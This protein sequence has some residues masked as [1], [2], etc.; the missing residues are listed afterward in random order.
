[1]QPV[2]SGNKSSWNSTVWCQRVRS[3][4]PEFPRPPALIQDPLTFRGTW[5][6][7]GTMAASLSCRTRS[8]SQSITLSARRGT[9]AAPRSTFSRMHWVTVKGNVAE[10]SGKQRLKGEGE[11]KETGLTWA[12]CWLLQGHLVTV[13]L[14]LT[15]KK[16]QPECHSLTT[17]WWL[18]SS[19]NFLSTFCSSPS[20]RA[21][22]PQCCPGAK[23]NP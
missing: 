12:Q 5:W 21:T 20:T 17:S 13:Q 9:R 18:R 14:T 16:A 10:Q 11:L 4:R 15:L 23:L 1:M 8:T 7:M 3:G 6:L 22:E 2:V 19:A